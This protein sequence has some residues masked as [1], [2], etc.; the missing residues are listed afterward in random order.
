MIARLALVVLLAGAACGG[1]AEQGAERTKQERDEEPTLIADP[2]FILDITSPEAGQSVPSAALTEI[3]GEF[4]SALV[5]VERVDVALVQRGESCAWW[6]ADRGRLVGAACD[7]PMW[8]PAVLGDGTWVLELM[9][10]LP[11]GTWT[12]MA[13][14]NDDYGTASG[15]TEIRFVVT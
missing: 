7:Q 5:D 8:N 13:G 15:T 9:D 6:S 14:A 1:N 4:V 3:S 12:A 2:A 10:P 11:A